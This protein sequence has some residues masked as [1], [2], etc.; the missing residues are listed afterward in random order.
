D[1]EQPGP[2]ITLI[3]AKVFDKVILFSTPKTEEITSATEKAI[4][5]LHPD[6]DIEIKGLPLE[7]PTDYIGI[8]R[9]LRKHFEEISNNA[10]DAKYFISVASGTPQMHACW[11]LLAS[12][13]EIPAHILH[14]RPPRFVTKDRPIISDVDLTS[15]E[16]PIVRSNILNIDT[17]DDS[18]DVNKVIA[19]LGIVGDHPSIAKALEN[20]ATLAQS[21]APMIIL[22]E[23]GTGKEIFAKFIHLLSNRASGQFVPINCAAIPGALVESLLFGHKKGSFTGATNDQLGKFDHADGGTL[24]LDELGELPLSTQAKLLRVLQDG[25]VEPV[26]D[27]KPHKVDVRIIAATN[28]DIGLA[29]KEGRFREDL[30]HRLH[31]GEI[32][33]PPLRERRS[34]IPKMAIHVLDRINNANAILNR[35]RKLSLGALERLQTHSW[36]GN[37]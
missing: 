37:V 6:I 11:V 26:G 35:P 8:L 25:L 21:T 10:R 20:A 36:P 31:V 7:D 5:S 34:D 24:F 14:T 2:I 1:D 9:G 27:K 3:N 13:G 16:F 18:P 30:Y 19:Q 22:G 28:K 17:V 23:T 33:L 15:P 4:R 32:K 12:S 29:I